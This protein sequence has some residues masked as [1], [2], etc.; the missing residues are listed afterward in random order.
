MKIRKKNHHLDFRFVDK[1]SQIYKNYKYLIKK[2]WNRQ[3]S[4]LCSSWKPTNI[5]IFRKYSI[6]IN[7]MNSYLFIHFLELE[8]L[9]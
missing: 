7:F 1:I 4:L 6:I 8:F 2:I 5:F 9:E 3:D